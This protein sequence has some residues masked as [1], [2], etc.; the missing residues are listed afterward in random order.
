MTAI[1]KMSAWRR[2]AAM[3]NFALVEPDNLIHHNIVVVDYV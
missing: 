2:Q 3:P 1:N